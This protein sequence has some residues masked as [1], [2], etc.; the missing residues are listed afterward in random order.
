MTQLSK[1][2]HQLNFGYASVTPGYSETL[3][4]EERPHANAHR[5]RMS[6]DESA[7]LSSNVASNHSS[8]SSFIPVAH[9]HRM[10]QPKTTV[11][12]QPQPRVSRSN[13]SKPALPAKPVPAAKPC[14]PI[15]PPRSSIESSNSGHQRSSQMHQSKSQ[16]NLATYEEIGG[17]SQGWQNQKSMESYSHVPPPEGYGNLFRC[18]DEDSKTIGLHT[19]SSGISSLSSRVKDDSVLDPYSQEPLYDEIGG[20]GLQ[21]SSR[22]NSSI[23]SFALQYNNSGR[24]SDNNSMDQQQLPDQVFAHNKKGSQGSKLHLRSKSEHHYSSTHRQALSPTNSSSHHSN[25]QHALY[26]Q[27]PAN[28][29]DKMRRDRSS[30]RLDSHVGNV[31][32]KWVPTV[33]YKPHNNGTAY[34]EFQTPHVRLP[35]QDEY[36][37]VTKPPT[38][39]VALKSIRN[40]IK[41][42]SQ[43]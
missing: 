32:G 28:G 38:A 20:P 35:S 27:I 26:E 29:S 19:S 24:S 23:S 15:K 16:R 17:S 9:V 1:S 42:L 34:K 4:Q 36:A 8:F 21:T 13:S 6:E 3:D 40:V 18:N 31:T 39:D 30:E 7:Y 25:Q 33:M 5:R 43:V 14:P 2:Q 37:L 10:D 41:M 22:I 12:P 11:K